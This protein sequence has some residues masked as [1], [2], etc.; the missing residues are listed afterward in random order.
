MKKLLST[1]MH[2]LP[3]AYEDVI[4]DESDA[5][6]LNEANADAPEWA[7]RPELHEQVREEPYTPNAATA[8]RFR[9]VCLL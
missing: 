7:K 6:T 4:A 8:M 2:P 9:G 1:P 3:C 5:V